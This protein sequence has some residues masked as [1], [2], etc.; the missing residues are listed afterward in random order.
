MYDHRLNTLLQS[1]T[2]EKV[3]RQGCCHAPVRM[4]ISLT[5]PHPFDLHVVV[6]VPIWTAAP[7]SRHSVES[8]KC[9]V[10]LRKR[11]S[12][13]KLGAARSQQIESI[14]ISMNLFLPEEIKRGRVEFW[15]TIQVTFCVASFR[16]DLPV[17]KIYSRA[18]VHFNDSVA[19]FATVVF[20]LCDACWNYFFCSFILP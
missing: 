3:C 2:F 8:I 14:P 11:P 18:K 12:W 5:P 10:W 19:T 13:W 4:I 20:L 1:I 7:H 16:N 9:L 17:T 15:I 6:V